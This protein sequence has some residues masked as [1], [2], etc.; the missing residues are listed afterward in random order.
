MRGL[1][2]SKEYF[3]GTRSRESWSALAESLVAGSPVVIWKGKAPD[4]GCELVSQKCLNTPP[5]TPPTQHAY[6]S[7]HE[8]RHRL[9][10]KPLN[11]KEP[12]LMI[13]ILPYFCRSQMM[14]TLRSG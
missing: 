5:P 11:T 13:L 12:N 14:V 1:V 9:K 7:M 6:T 2:G 8:G 10:E 4:E 3:L